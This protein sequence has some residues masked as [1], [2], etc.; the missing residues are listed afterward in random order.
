MP[1]RNSNFLPDLFL[2]NSIEQEEPDSDIPD[3]PNPVKHV[4]NFSSKDLSGNHNNQN[5]HNNFFL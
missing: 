3:N 1:T 4:D 5:N 2:N